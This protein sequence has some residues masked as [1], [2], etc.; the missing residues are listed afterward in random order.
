MEGK[1]VKETMSSQ[2]REKKQ[3]FLLYN[4]AEIKGR[5]QQCQTSEVKRVKKNN[6]FLVTLEG[7]RPGK[8]M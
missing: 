3:S 1:K 5:R 4:G 8:T 7:A 2:Q 6:R